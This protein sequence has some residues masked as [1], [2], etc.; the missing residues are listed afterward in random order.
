MHAHCSCRDIRIHAHYV[1]SVR[2]NQFVNYILS[3]STITIAFYEQRILK[4]T[5]ARTLIN[6]PQEIFLSALS[7]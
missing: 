3:I 2:F 5:H 6:N 1:H 7:Y 4:N